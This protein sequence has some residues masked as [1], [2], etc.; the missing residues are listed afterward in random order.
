MGARLA[1]NDQQDTSVLGGAI[2]DRTNGS[3]LVSIEAERRLSDRFKLEFEARL[4][5]GTAVQDPLYAF[6]NDS[7]LTLRVSRFF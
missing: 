7:F 2:I 3:T 5:A 4:F 1:F 6:R